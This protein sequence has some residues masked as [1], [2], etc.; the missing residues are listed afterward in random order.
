VPGEK[1]K[2]IKGLIR[3]EFFSPAGFDGCKLDKPIGFSL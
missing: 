2:C 1:N 3:E